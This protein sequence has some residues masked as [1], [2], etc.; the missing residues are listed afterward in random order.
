M[1]IIITERF[2]S[3][4]LHLR[5]KFFKVKHFSLGKEMKQSIDLQN[6]YYMFSHAEGCYAEKNCGLFIFCGR[7]SENRV[8]MLC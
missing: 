3:G 6:F 2:G 8:D 1:E 5:K 7:N 4:E